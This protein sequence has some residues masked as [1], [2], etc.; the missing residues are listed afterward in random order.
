LSAVVTASTPAGPDVLEAA[1][2][3]PVLWPSA[4]TKTVAKYAVAVAGFGVV[5]ALGALLPFWYLSAPESGAA[6]FPSAGLTVAMLLLTHRR[7]WPLWLAAAGVAELIVD[8]THG[9]AV[10]LAVG[11]AVANVAEPFVGAKAMIR[12]MGG[13]LSYM[14]RALVAFLIGAVT[15]G[16]LVGAA[17]GASVSVFLGDASN[18]FLV[19]GKWWLGDAIGV[20]VIASVILAW[21][22]VPATEARR[23][24]LET[25]AI[26]ATT[27][28]LMVVPALLWDHPMLYA[29]LPVLVW[30]AFRGG[31]RV[32]ALAGAVVAFSADWATVTGRANQ[33]VA[34]A[35]I[36]SQL[37]LTQVFIGVTLITAL[38]LAVEVADRRR[39]EQEAREAEAA[40]A[41]TEREVLGIGAAERRR[42]ARDTHDI[43]GHGLNVMLLQTGAARRVLDSD[44]EL[45]RELLRSI[46]AVGRRACQELDIAL[47]AEDPAAA[48]EAGRGLDA[49][50]QLVDG[51]RA[52][53]LHVD[54][55]LHGDGVPISTLVDWSAY[56]IVQEA[57]T[58]VAKHAPLAQATVRITVGTS[59]V[60]LMI[61]DDGYGTHSNGTVVEGRGLIGMRERVVALGGS[62]HAGP[63]AP[64]GFEVRAYLPARVVA[65]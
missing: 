15:I 44:R 43:V 35:T 45:A 41:A 9:Q 56:R 17:I 7:T 34:S 63:V 31:V 55:D 27:T 29:V 24:I 25:A 46:E 13:P 14:R 10:V 38:T 51:M 52:A 65:G 32:V 3:R 28:A 4:R 36:S 26:V 5:Y 8:L 49:V 50:P 20:L 40:R 18:W 54:L 37:A 53:G 64:R 57:L 61:A 6:F 11:F 60:S 48:A 2:P 16:P 42:I 30:A 58:N 62:L 33:L 1:S 22:R 47:S 39:I 12:I 59:A 21:A 19:A 23:T